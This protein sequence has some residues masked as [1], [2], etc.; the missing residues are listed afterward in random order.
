MDSVNL[1][2]KAVDSKDEA[3]REIITIL[4]EENLAVPFLSNQCKMEISSTKVCETLFR[5]TSFCTKS[6]DYFMKLICK[7]YLED[8]VGLIIK[9]I[10][11][12]HKN[13]EIDPKKL[14]DENGDYLV[15]SGQVP[16]ENIENLKE[17]AR[18]LLDSIIAS[19]E[20]FPEELSE[21]F[22]NIQSYA[23]KEFPKFKN[24][25]FSC[26]SAFIFLR[27]FSP[28]ILNPQLFGLIDE[29]LKRKEV[30][31]L[32]L[33]SK[34]V[35]QTANLVE[36]NNSKENYM[37]VLNDLVKEY[38]PSIKKFINSI[39]QVQQKSVM[40]PKKSLFNFGNIN[41]FK[42]KT[43]DCNIPIEEKEK[44]QANLERRFS[45]VHRLINRNLDNI[46]KAMNNSIEEIRTFQKLKKV[47]EEL[48]EK[49]GIKKK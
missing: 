22:N 12:Q 23:I 19:F 31:T 3:V 32:T 28:A 47:I 17:Y 42:K 48:N 40:K 45:S 5:G 20:Y 16:E 6:V 36:Y 13:C 46:K 44:N 10:I 33:L 26:I 39:S 41:I 9:R 2:A 8:T 4:N 37:N 38:I 21:L 15:D 43:N 14:L 7:N 1:L 25:R 24:V 35:Q 34:F 11:K 18:L 30:R 49:A 27:L 29:N